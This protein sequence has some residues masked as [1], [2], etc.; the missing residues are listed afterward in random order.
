[1]EEGLIS[2]VVPIYK[3]EKYLV[4]CID[5]IIE[6]SYRNIELILVDDGS[7][8]SCPQICDKYKSKDLRVRVIHK[9]NGGLS[10]ARNAGLKIATGE[11]ITFIDSDDYVGVNF[12]KKLYFAAINTN[13]DIS[14]CDYQ[15]VLDDAGQ[16][17]EETCTKAYNNVKCLEEM[18]HPQIHGME[19]VAWGK[20]YRTELFKKNKIQYPVGK[21]H[22]DTF[23]TYKLI[24]AAKKIVF[25][26][27][28]EYF[29]RQREASIM[30][31]SFN[32]ERLAV[33][34]ATRE[35]CQFFEN[36]REPKLLELAINA[37]FRNYVS[38]YSEIV[39]N[40]D[41]IED[42]KTERKKIIQNFRRD[43]KRYSKNA[44]LGAKKRAFYTLFYLIPGAI[45]SV[46]CK[47]RRM[48]IT[49]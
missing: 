12:L 4:K 33:I 48:N 24:Y 36:G 3:V 26:N 20:L 43:Y 9:Q 41:I 46:F 7:P 27:A 1:M 29:Y 39:K 13:A 8:D 16:E 14:M 18:Y 19:F 44:N 34:D 15:S 42:F 28:C 47:G 22:E 40:K 21:L 32:I 37:Y 38:M 10:D 45:Y 35:A 11:W 5:S 2:V 17:K 25:S 30:T 23:T 31:S 49:Q 6:Q